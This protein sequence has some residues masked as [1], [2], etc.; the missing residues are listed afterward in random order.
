MSGNLSCNKKWI[1]QYCW[2]TKHCLLMS[3]LVFYFDLLCYLLLCREL[4][5]KDPKIAKKNWIHYTCHGANYL[6]YLVNRIA[7]FEKCPGLCKFVRKKKCPYPQE[8]LTNSESRIKSFLTYSLV[9]VMFPPVEGL[10]VSQKETH[11]T[12]W[13][14]VLMCLLSP[15]VSSQSGTYCM[16]H[17]LGFLK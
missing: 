2:L 12:W 4:K 6:Y 10:N 9:L 5:W 17:S 15:R 1:K 13:S 11:L 16:S 7:A 3:K 14:I 8:V